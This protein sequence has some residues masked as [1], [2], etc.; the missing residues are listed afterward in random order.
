MKVFHFKEKVDSLP[1][2]VDRILPP[3]HIRIKP[4]NVCNHNC[5]YCAYRVDNLQLG[6]DMVTK[7][8]I[9]RE[10]MLEI[11][12]DIVEMEGDNLQ[13]RRRT[14]CL[15]AFAGGREEIVRCSSQV[16]LPD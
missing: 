13:R 3:L 11:I 10:K 16:R 9:P 5:G 6:K 1:R 8:Q 12:D 2:D 7:N 4:T 15:S 14:L